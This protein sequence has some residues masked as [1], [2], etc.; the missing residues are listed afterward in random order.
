MTADTFAMT[1]SC[2]DRTRYPSISL[3]CTTH[4]ASLTL[5]CLELPQA[6]SM[7]AL[8]A[9]LL[10][11]AVQLRCL[12]LESCCLAVPSF[13]GCAELFA[14]TT[15]LVLDRTFE[16]GSVLTDSLAA[17]L[18]HTPQLR[19]LQ[20]LGLGPDD[21]ESLQ[22]LEEGEALAAG[23]PPA[24]AALPQLEHLTIK[25]Y[26]LDTLPDGPYLDR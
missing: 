8:L 26:L 10:P 20:L 13:S 18:Q 21:Y 6:G 25:G 3:E 24:L 22:P 1:G 15:E 4:G 12:K 16:E 19:R 17:L 23:L 5:T 2:R 11:P 9:G 7:Q 14:A